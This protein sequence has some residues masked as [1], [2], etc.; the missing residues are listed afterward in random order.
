V[1]SYTSQRWVPE[2]VVDPIRPGWSTN[3]IIPQIPGMADSQPVLPG[4]RPNRRVTGVDPFNR[5]PSIPGLSGQPRIPGVPG[6]PGNQG[7]QPQGQW[8]RQ[9]QAIP[10]YRIDLTVAV[11]HWPGKTLAGIVSI[12]GTNPPPNISRGPSD[13]RPEYGDPYQPLAQWIAG[14]P[15]LADLPGKPA[16][17]RQP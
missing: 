14:L 7:V 8:V 2:V 3:P 15:R 5:Q 9:G 11:I 10:G 13:T 17:S 6:F 4:L 16:K 12:S 1:I